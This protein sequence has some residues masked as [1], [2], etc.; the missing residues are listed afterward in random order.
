V[1]VLD[2]ATVHR[3]STP[4]LIDFSFKTQRQQSRMIEHAL[5][6]RHQRAQL[7]LVTHLECRRQ[8]PIFRAGAIV[9][10]PECHRDESL[11]IAMSKRRF[12]REPDFDAS[13]SSRMYALQIGRQGSGIVRNHQIA[14][15]QEIHQL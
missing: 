4:K 2:G 15:T 1:R 14:W 9:A 10:R 6:T 12:A 8:R 7:K 3:Q 11:R 13:S 5:D